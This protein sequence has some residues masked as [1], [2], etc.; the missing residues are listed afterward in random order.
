MRRSHAWRIIGRRTS[1]WWRYEQACVGSSDGQ[2]SYPT[3]CGH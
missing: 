3:C 2:R 1:T